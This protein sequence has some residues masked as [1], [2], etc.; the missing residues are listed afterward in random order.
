MIYAKI[1]LFN[2]NL[3]AQMF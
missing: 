2:V 3:K 1:I